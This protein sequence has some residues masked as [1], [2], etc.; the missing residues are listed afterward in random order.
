[1]IDEAKGNLEDTSL[2]EQGK[3]KLIDLSV[4]ATQDIT[5]KKDKTG[6]SKK[7]TVELGEIDGIKY[8]I[9]AI[10]QPENG[11]KTEN[12]IDNIRKTVLSPEIKES[13]ILR[14]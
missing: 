3:R 7:T 9:Q 5:K 4:T 14:N 1:M 6:K 11:S 10:K 12:I 13:L 8:R 2:N